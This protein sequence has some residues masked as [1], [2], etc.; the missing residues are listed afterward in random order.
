M[1]FQFL[2]QFHANIQVS[3]LREAFANNL[4]ANIK[5]SKTELHKIGQSEGFWVDF[6]DHD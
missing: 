4:S 5:I 6:Q 2:L 3:R 1:L